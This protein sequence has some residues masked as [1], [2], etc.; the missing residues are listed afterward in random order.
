M[1]V[2]D[3]EDI[4]MRASQCLNGT[5][6]WNHDTYCGSMVVTGKKLGREIEFHV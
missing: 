2:K 1:N 3:L 4:T 5:S 6:N